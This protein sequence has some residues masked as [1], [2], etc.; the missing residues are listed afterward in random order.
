MSAVIM[1]QTF[2]KGTIVFSC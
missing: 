1:M 2:D